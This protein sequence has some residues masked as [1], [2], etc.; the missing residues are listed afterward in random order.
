MNI[1][2]KTIIT[3][4]K[5]ILTGALAISIELSLL[6]LLRTKTDIWYLYASALTSLVSFSISFTLRKLWVFKSFG[7]HNLL[8]QFFLYILTLLVV[9][10]ITTMLVSLFI[11]KIHLNYLLAQFLAGLLAGIFGFIVNRSITFKEQDNILKKYFYIIKNLLS[12]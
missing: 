9:V 4:V 10:G 1:E 8:R 6:Y 5:Y 3:F 11:L 12:K 7:R 2:K